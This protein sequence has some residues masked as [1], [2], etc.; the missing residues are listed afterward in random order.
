MQKLLLVW[1]AGDIEEA[2]L[3]HPFGYADLSDDAA[4]RF[5]FKKF[6]D[7]IGLFGFTDSD[8]ETSSLHAAVPILYIR[9]A[10]PLGM[11]VHHRDGGPT[12]STL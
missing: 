6:L 5:T 9:N 2:A 12:L 4:R 10:H 11:L 3:H 1:T 7:E 8:E